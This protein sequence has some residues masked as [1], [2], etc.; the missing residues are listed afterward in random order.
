MPVSSI[1]YFSLVIPGLA[2]LYLGISFLRKKN[3]SIVFNKIK[4][5]DYLKNKEKMGSTLFYTGFVFT[6]LSP[7]SPSLLGLV[8]YLGSRLIYIGI[9]YLMFS[10]KDSKKNVYYFLSAFITVAISLRAGMFGELVYWGGLIFVYYTSAK[11]WGILRKVSITISGILFIFVLQT[12][13]NE[14]RKIQ[15]GGNLSMT[16]SFSVANNVAKESDLSFSLFDINSIAP[17][18]TRFNQGYI[19]ALAMEYTPKFEP[20]AEGETIFTGFLASFVPRIF[21]PDKPTTGGAEAME[22]FV[23]WKYTSASYNIG[24]MGDAYV[25]FGITGGAFFMFFYGLVLGFTENRVYVLSKKRPDIILWL[26]LIL[27]PAILVESDIAQVFNHIVKAAFFMW[28]FFKFF[29]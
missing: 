28:V 20:F 8:F 9:I 21:W 12:F 5:T 1:D 2:F 7:F 27:L 6:V 13:K 17:Q 11:N 18:L 4:I 10:P 14:Y 3:N 16:E 24:Q 22:R 29:K 15:W 19:T 23:G 25:N 26:P